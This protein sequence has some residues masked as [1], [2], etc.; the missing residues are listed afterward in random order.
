MQL[1][2]VEIITLYLCIIF[3]E[4]W[5]SRSI[6]C[7]SKIS[8]KYRYFYI[9]V[10][11]CIHLF[12]AH[13]RTVALRFSLSLTEI[14]LQPQMF[15]EKPVILHLTTCWCS[16][17]L[18]SYTLIVLFSRVISASMLLVVPITCCRSGLI[19]VAL[20]TYSCCHMRGLDD[21][22]VEFTNSKA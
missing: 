13:R 14:L 11:L 21:Y 19:S 1:V 20:A 9:C 6:K 16:P 2:K 17:W 3:S 5:R 10:Y 18:L 8:L 7:Q 15:L 22:S 4:M 12:A